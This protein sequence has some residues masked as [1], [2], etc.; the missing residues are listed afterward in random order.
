MRRTDDGGSMTVVTV[1][2][3]AI[4][5]TL[6]ATLGVAGGVAVAETRAQGAADAAA[7]AVAFDARDRRALGAAYVGTGAAPCRIAV[8]VSGRWGAHL[9]AC[10][11]EPGGIVSVE[12]AVSTC[13][14]AVGAEA[15][16][17]PSLGER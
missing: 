11:V 12:V 3:V 5:A 2:V 8:E 13:V 7:L 16:A 1:G 9:V 17:G 14:G 6:A 10:S 4:A 15:T